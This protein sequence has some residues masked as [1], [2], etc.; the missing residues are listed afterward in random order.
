[1][2]IL[3]I[4]VEHKTATWRL[5]EAEML[6]LAEL[7]VE[8]AAIDDPVALKRND[9]SAHLIGEDIWDALTGEYFNRFYEDGV[10]DARKGATT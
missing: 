3:T 4:D 6:Y 10:R 9:K 5:T 2:K 8:F 1:M 7:V